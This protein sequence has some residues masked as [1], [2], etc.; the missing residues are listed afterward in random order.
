MQTAEDIEF[1]DNT[2]PCVATTVALSYA[3]HVK[4][5][6]TCGKDWPA[7][8]V[9]ALVYRLATWPVGEDTKDTVAFFANVGELQA[10]VKELDAWA[11][12]E[13]NGWRLIDLY[14]W[15]LGPV[16]VVQDREMHLYG[17]PTL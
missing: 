7:D 3:D 9:Y 2:N 6:Q 10:K 12:L 17:S 13:D 5:H 14:M 16:L 11:Q 15:D 8:A 1:G 4:S